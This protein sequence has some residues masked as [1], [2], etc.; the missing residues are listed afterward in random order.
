MYTVTKRYRLR[1]IQGRSNV[2]IR[3]NI[4]NEES[5]R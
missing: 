2:L 1:N 4:F 5:R 3:D